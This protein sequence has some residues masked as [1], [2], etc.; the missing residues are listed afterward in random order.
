MQGVEGSDV[1]LDET[2]MVHRLIRHSLS[3]V[4][5]TNVMSELRFSRVQK[6]M[7]SS[8]FGRACSV[9]TLASKHFLSE[10]SAMHGRAAATW[11][12]EHPAQSWVKPHSSK[13]QSGWHAYFRDHRA[14]HKASM[15]DA[16][17]SWRGLS[18]DERR[19]YEEAA[20]GQAE[21]V[22]SEDDYDD[23]GAGR[24]PPALTPLG[25]GAADTPLREDV[26]SPLCKGQC[27]K[28]KCAEWRR[29]FGTRVPEPRESPLEVEAAG[30]SCYE[31][32][33]IRECGS[34]LSA[35][36][37]GRHERLL[38]EVRVAA[39]RLR[40]E[41]NLT[42]LV[43]RKADASE[44]RTAQHFK[45]LLTCFTLTQPKASGLNDFCWVIA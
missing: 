27:A 31:K 44:P 34:K 8:K 13:L 30:L 1:I 35:E 7:G 6:H 4:R 43:V 3:Q 45:L 28:Q 16:A 20:R 5:A 26:V 11:D 18:P 23:Q 38:A 9:S 41:A 32:Y 33:G 24:I 21:D 19:P 17:A 40:K 10:F 15:A 36:L 37:K 39:F 25:L 12:K 14:K 29:R 22:A 2:S 42:L